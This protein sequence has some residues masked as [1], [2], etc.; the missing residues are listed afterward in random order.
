MQVK[1]IA[2]VNVSFMEVDFEATGGLVI[3]RMGKV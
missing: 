2:I 3:V 1:R